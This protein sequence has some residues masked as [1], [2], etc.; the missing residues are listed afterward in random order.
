MDEGGNGVK[1]FIVE[2]VYGFHGTQQSFLIW[3]RDAALSVAICLWPC[4]SATSMA[5]SSALLIVLV[6]PSSLGRTLETLLDLRLNM[7][8]RV[9]LL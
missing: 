5:E 7:V 2:I 8:C 4:S 1:Q 3:R 9:Q 6:G